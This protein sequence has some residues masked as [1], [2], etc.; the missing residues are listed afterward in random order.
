MES[1][2][3]SPWTNG[4]E[5]G[6]WVSACWYDTSHLPKSKFIQLL[7]VPV[8]DSKIQNRVC[9]GYVYILSDDLIIWFSFLY[10]LKCLQ[11]II[12]YSA[13][14]LAVPEGGYTPGTNISLSKA[15]LKMMLLFPRCVSSLEGMI[16]VDSTQ[17][18]SCDFAA[19][20]YPSPIKGWSHY[21]L[22][23][24]FKSARTVG[25]KGLVFPEAV[26]QSAL[27]GGGGLFLQVKCMVRSK[28]TVIY[29]ILKPQTL[30]GSFWCYNFAT[31]I[32]TNKMWNL[33]AA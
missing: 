21:P 16:I 2:I 5:G 7:F 29:S 26:T 18:S 25:A 9:E 12:G 15:V 32:V 20:P 23:Y 4:E 11:S 14:K 8:I 3:K 1:I 19:I 17:L 33:G 28:N 22:H 6:R 31:R 10:H 27:A 13:G 30:C 24:R